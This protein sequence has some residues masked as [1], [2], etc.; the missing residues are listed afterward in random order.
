MKTSRLAGMRR[1]SD[2]Y[3]TPACMVE[4]VIPHLRKW[5]GVFAA[6][7][8]RKPIVLCPFD[9]ED[10][11]YVHAFSGLDFIECLKYGHV[12]T[13]QD[14]FEYDYGEWDVCVSNPPFS[15]KMEVFERLDSTGK[16]WALL[17]NTM[18]LNYNVVNEYFSRQ[19]YEMQRLVFTK[20]MT[21]DGR[22]SAFNSSYICREFM[23]RCTNYI[24]ME[25][26]NVGP[27]FVP[28]RMMR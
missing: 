10:S 8:R 18:I 9:T 22:T 21:F 2:L 26:D 11:E 12:D 16:P 19:E 13:G 4:P 7:E 17:M 24:V 23:P 3:F 27:R 1:S 20:K 25:R 5:A 14:F 28:S 15:R 6:V